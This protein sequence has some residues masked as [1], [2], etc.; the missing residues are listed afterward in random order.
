VGHVW[1]DCGGRT[2]ST[3][4]G[5]M[6]GLEINTGTLETRCVMTRGLLACYQFAADLN[7]RSLT[8]EIFNGHALTYPRLFSVCACREGLY[9]I[10]TSKEN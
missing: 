8:V 5:P 4:R 7:G 2:T 3:G 10:H 1:V 9:Y 6:A